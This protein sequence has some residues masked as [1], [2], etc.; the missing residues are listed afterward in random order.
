M[1][2][3]NNTLPTSSFQTSTLE[4][5]SQ[6]LDWFTNISLA[7]DLPVEVAFLIILGVFLNLTK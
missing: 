2:L 6:K 1:Q 3:R 5:D 4:D 7:K